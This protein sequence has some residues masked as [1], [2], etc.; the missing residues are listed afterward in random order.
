MTLTP[1]DV[2]PLIPIRDDLNVQLAYLTSFINS[3]GAP[4]PLP[5]SPLPGVS[6]DGTIIHVPV[7]ADGTVLDTIY[8]TK[9]PPPGSIT[10]PGGHVWT[11]GTVFIDGWDCGYHI[12][13]DGVERYQGGV[14][15]AMQL[16]SGS[17]FVLGRAVANSDAGG[18]WWKD[19]GTAWV[20]ALGGPV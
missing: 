9:Q 3:A 2:A 4:T 11:W 17:I 16:K 8:S 10:D 13:R 6:P 12:L 7:N 18:T 14:A 1:A 19:N 20:I 15:V 5:P